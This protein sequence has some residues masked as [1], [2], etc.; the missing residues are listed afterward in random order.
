MTF[1][2]VF[3][4]SLVILIVLILFLFVVA[5]F[6][7]IKIDT[8]YKFQ[9]HEQRATIFIK[10][11]FG[12]FR[13]RIEIPSEKLKAKNEIQSSKHDEGTGQHDDEEDL[14]SFE[15]IKQVLHHI[16]ELYDILKEFFKKVRI[17]EFEW[18]SAIGTGNAASAAII[19]G[20]GWAFKGNVIGIISNYFSLKVYPKLEI[21]PVFNR[22]TSETYL[23]CMIQV[24]VGHAILAGIKLL[25]FW[26]KNV[27]KNSSSPKP[28]KNGP[29][30][31]EQSI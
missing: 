27:S 1:L 3:F 25:R 21:T 11:F 15:P 8:T 24:K 30:G 4:V 2:K 31:E 19:A 26:K 29:T 28:I 17:V 6:T 12:L 16:H 5:I 10:A 7:R 14:S 22:A 23:R 18:K 13:Y 9:P 20:A